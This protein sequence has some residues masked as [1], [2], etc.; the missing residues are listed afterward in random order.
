MKQ[1]PFPGQG[2]KNAELG[3]PSEF[4][5][6]EVTSNLARDRRMVELPAVRHL[7][8]QLED[9]AE[10]A[11]L[12]GISPDRGKRA[13]GIA[14]DFMDRSMLDR[15]TNRF[16]VERVK[17]DRRFAKVNE[18]LDQ[19]AERA[20]Q[21]HTYVRDQVLKGREGY[22]ES[23]MDGWVRFVQGK[24][25][26]TKY[27]IS[28][29]PKL[30]YAP[31]IFVEIA[32]AV[33]P[34][35]SYAMNLQ[36]TGSSYG[37][38]EDRADEVTVFASQQNLARLLPIIEKVYRARQEH[39]VG[40]LSSGE[41][42]Y[43]PLDGVSIGYTNQ[44]RSESKAANAHDVSTA[45]DGAMRKALSAQLKRIV[46][47]SFKD[48]K[49]FRTSVVGMIMWDTLLSNDGRQ[50]RPKIGR[51]TL[52][53]GARRKASEPANDDDEQLSECYLKGM[54]EE[55]VGSLFEDRPIDRERI[56]QNF[57]RQLQ[58]QMVLNHQWVR[59]FQSP[60]AVDRAVSWPQASPDLTH[61]T[62]VAS[63]AASVY[64]RER[65]E[66]PVGGAIEALLKNDRFQPRK[67]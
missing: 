45:I 22:I 38:T 25:E 14:S 46:Q 5:L 21:A 33:P 10:G 42:V 16:T 32:R 49:Q 57:I 18:L 52:D 31:G 19:S 56:R 2:P 9:L 51:W 67:P 35:L 3:L 64:R 62:Q 58:H 27:R 40:Q 47:G 28:L 41:G 12:V 29:S 44:Q 53:D 61:A 54:Y 8:A 48:W 36:S 11:E 17:G 34:E 59:K 50:R 15:V 39:F 7:S 30:P 4:S 37:A 26:E 66:E 63:L 43:S 24:P 13:V 6:S 65:A 20:A 23:S 60:G 55:W 1:R